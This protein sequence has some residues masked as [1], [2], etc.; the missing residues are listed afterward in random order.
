[1]DL[2]PKVFR[3]EGDLV[4]FDSSRILESILKET[5]MS[6]ENAEKITELVVRRIISSGIKFL[7]GPHIREIVCSILSEQHFENER[8]LY[9][10]IGMPLMDYEKILENG[11][12]RPPKRIINPEK[13][14]NWA[15]NRISEEYAHLRI[16]SSEESKAHLYGNIHIHKL[17]YFDLRPFTQFWDPRIV[18]EEGLPPITNFISCCKLKPA[19][20]LTQAIHHLVKWVAFTQ[21]EFCGTQ[22]FNKLTLFL[23]PYAKDL[24]QSEL[25][26]RIRNMLYEL[27]HLTAMTGRT[28]SSSSLCTSPTV[29]TQFLKVSTKGMNGKEEGYYGDYQDECLKLFNAFTNIFKEGDENKDPFNSP[30]REILLSKSLLDKFG[31]AY[32]N[33][34]EEIYSMKTSIL[35]N[36]KVDVLNQE[37]ID[38]N[39]SGNYLNS[40]I[41]QEI[42]MNLPRFAYT[43][44][45]IDN[46]F[47]IIRD[48]M[49]ISNQILVKKNNIIKE[50]LK[51]NHLPLCSGLINN[52]PLFNLDDQYLSISFIG[53]NEATKFLTDYELHEHSNSFNFGKKVLAEMNKMCLELSRKYNLHFKLSENISKKASNRFARLD[54]KHFPKIAIPQSNRDTYYY[55]NSIHF[56]KDA[57]IDLIKRIKKQEEYQSFIQIGAI[58]YVSLDD[59]KSND[60]NLIDFINNIF[61]PSNLASLKFY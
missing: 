31:D 22:G 52:K 55:T 28:I 29:P 2:F 38:S 20:T 47:E 33:V 26:Q 21:N 43:S 6:E 13:I 14:H 5:G 42:C 46:F 34:W 60:L 19:K 23:A 10:R 39:S 12:G 44:K 57:E 9:T 48:S 50:R 4:V 35:I 1:M 61:I 30:K 3:T 11:L 27:N 15:A 54:L 25:N 8:K 17:R 41:L 53:L 51:S 36:S 18:L 24:N 58:E 56:K 59:L 45:D 37:A 32:Q 7:S 40:G 49:N 16:L